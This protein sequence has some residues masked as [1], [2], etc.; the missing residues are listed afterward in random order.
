MPQVLQLFGLSCPQISVKN[1]MTSECKPF[2]LLWGDKAVLDAVTT[3]D[4]HFQYYP[5]AVRGFLKTI[6]SV[7]LNLHQGLVLM[8]V[9]FLP[10]C[11]PPS[12]PMPGKG[13]I[14]G[15]P[16]DFNVQLLCGIPVM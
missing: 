4:H 10:F 12:P 5:G 13:K 14:P 3:H 6:F 2:P 16:E 9:F 8:V 7:D 15:K 11:S 1:E